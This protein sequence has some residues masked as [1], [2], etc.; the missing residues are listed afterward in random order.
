MIEDKELGLKIS[1]SPEE[2]LWER[3]K[4]STEAE[5]KALQ[6]SLTIQTAI[7]EMAETKLKKW[8]KDKK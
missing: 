8:S 3:V 1:E 6:D 7:K 4:K 2:T 5:I